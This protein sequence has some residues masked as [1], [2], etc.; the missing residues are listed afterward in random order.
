LKSIKKTIAVLSLVLLVYALANNALAVT[1]YGASAVRENETYT[2]EQMLTYA[3]EDEYLAYERYLKDIE[4]FGVQR[5]FTNILRAEN[6]HIMLLG[7]LFK[8][9]HVPVPGNQAAQ[10]VT[11]PHTLSEA[12]KAGVEGEWLNMRMYDLFLR[13]EIPGDVRVVFTLLRNA[14]EN[15]LRAFER[16]LSRT[17]SRGLE[18]N[19]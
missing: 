13:Q 4:L 2:L 12:L 6:T 5:P 3:I 18:R 19:S 10:H 14:A 16:V 9:Y 8:N 17:E 11:T 7:P 1:E 15:H